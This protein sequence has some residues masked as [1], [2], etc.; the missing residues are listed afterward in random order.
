MGIFRF[1]FDSYQSLKKDYLSKK[2]HYDITTCNR[3]NELG[4][5]LNIINFQSRTPSFE[6]PVKIQ[7]KKRINFGDNLWKVKSKIGLPVLKIEPYLK[8]HDIYIHKMYIGHY[9]ST[10]ET[11]FY[12]GEFFMGTFNFNHH[13][14]RNRLCEL[15]INKY[16]SEKGNLDSHDNLSIVDQNGNSIQLSHIIKNSFIYLTGDQKLKNEILAEIQ[17]HID[18]EIA[19]KEE[20]INRM[21]ED[22]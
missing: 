7:F 1:V 5:L 19:Q 16:L 13:Q 9:K 17:E 8:N 22:L 4:V 20:D 12:K 18:Y 15:L 14:D 2:Y 6:T 11:H 10:I 3:Y 21:M